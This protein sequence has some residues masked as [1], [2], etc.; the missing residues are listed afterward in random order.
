MLL[1]QSVLQQKHQGPAL[2]AQEQLTGDAADLAGSRSYAGDL[3]DP[4]FKF[5]FSLTLRATSILAT[6]LAS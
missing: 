1:L 6:G 2:Q 4:T 3:N 5:D